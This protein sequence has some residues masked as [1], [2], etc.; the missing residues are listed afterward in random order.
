MIEGNEGVAAEG[1]LRLEAIAAAVGLAIV[2][3]SCNGG[4]KTTTTPPPPMGTLVLRFDHRIDDQPIAPLTEYTTRYG[5][6]VKF[7]HLRY[8]VSN[9]VLRRGDDEVAIPASY[10]LVEI[11]GKNTRTEV[12][13]QAPPGTYDAVVF[14]LGVDPEHN[15]SLDLAEGE[16]SAGIG[17]IGVE[18]R[19]QVLPH[20]GH[21]R[22]AGGRLP[23]S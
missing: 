9:V 5:Q 23:A 15:K 10:Y 22:R 1:Q 16:L 12:E 17:M 18:H 13:V 19:L 4:E 6:Q 8:W 20:R 2:G 3:L 21:L 11:T 7:D 14:H